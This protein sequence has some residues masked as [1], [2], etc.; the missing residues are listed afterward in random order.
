M[1]L[2]VNTFQI[3]IATNGSESFVQFLYADD[4][5]QWLQGQGSLNVTGLPDAKAQAGLTAYN[6]R[7]L[8]LPG[9]GTDQIRNLV[10]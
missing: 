10:R 3:V 8:M 6:G 1:P 7:I 9:S 4:G 5:I 2:Q